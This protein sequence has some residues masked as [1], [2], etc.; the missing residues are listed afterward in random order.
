[1]RSGDGG[2][3]G[4]ADGGGPARILVVDDED[5][6]HP[7]RLDRA[8]LR[9][10]RGADRGHR[11]GGPDRGRRASGPT[12]C[13]STSC[14]PTSTASRCTGA[15]PGRGERLPVVFLTARRETEDRVRG[16][17]IGAD[18]YVTKPFSLE[19]LIARVRAVLRRTRGDA[20]G[21]SGASPT[22]TSSS[23]RTPTRCA[24]PGRLIELTPDRVQ[25]AALPAGQRRPGAQQAA[26]PRPR[27]ALRLRRRR[28][29][30][31]DL[32][33]LPA[34]EA[35]RARARRSS[36]PCAASATRSAAAREE[37][38]P[39]RCARGCWLITACVGWS[40]PGSDGGRVGHR[41]VRCALVPAR[42]GRPAAPDG[43]EP[44]AALLADPRPRRP[45]RRP[46]RP[47]PTTVARAQGLPTASVVTGVFTD[48]GGDAGGIAAGPDFEIH[49]AGRGAPT[50]VAGAAPSPDSRTGA[51]R[52]RSP[53]GHARRRRP[54]RRTCSDTLSRLVLDR[55]R[56]R[57]RR[58]RGRRR[59]WR[60]WL[61]RLGLR[62]LTRIEH[63][64]GA[65]AA[66]DLS[67]RVEDEN[68]RT[69]VG[70]LGGAL[71]TMLG[72]I[73][74]AFAERQASEARLRQ[75]VAD[76]SHELQTPLTSV[77]GYAELFRRGRGR[78]PGRPGHRDAAHRGRG[79]RAWACWSTTCCCSPGSTR[80]ARWTREPVDLRGHRPRPGRPTP[81]SSTPA[82][83][84]TFDAP[85]AGRGRRRRACACARSSRTC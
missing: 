10:L 76:A 35:R 46:G 43:R 63:T 16:L 64:A 59:C 41:R 19:E 11:P 65:I 14:C 57:R 15:W 7:A 66:G 54:A 6:H 26:D 71:N 82:A 30:R 1:M 70:R 85:D 80:A 84:S 83:R 51:R 81:A 68:P 45:P 33:Q 17:T 24:A 55:A 56:R 75:F 20:S 62:P 69:E 79:R 12:S 73:E 44:A 31:G 21:R 67:R 47:R 27:L 5:E 61:V 50:A 49:R 39:C 36:T 3:N 34:Q 29:R 22:R 74:A 13:C 40:R 23:T 38:R 48:P 60:C 9:G 28:Q 42:P 37:S 25:P 77:R 32:H 8:A 4:R 72:R 18:D 52:R 78:A 58:A 2:P 53:D